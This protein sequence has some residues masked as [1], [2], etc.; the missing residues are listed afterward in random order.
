MITPTKL[1]LENKAWSEE[2]SRKD[3]EFFVQLAKEQKPDFL[4]I[5]CSDSRVPA[6]TVVNAKPGE[7]FVHRNIAN[8]VIVTDFNCLSVL[9]YAISVLKVKHVIV[10]GHYGC[11]GVRAA[12]QPQKSD[13]VITN[14]WLL[15]IKDVYR[16]HQEELESIAP[17]K[18]TDRLI[19]LNIIE[20]VYRLAH[21]SIIQSAWKHGHKPTLHGWVY[22]LNDGLINELIKLDHNTQINPIYRY[23][24]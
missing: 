13:L 19:E 10:C 14:K 5:G 23:A 22:G 24:D 2:V 6:E 18:K 8:Q 11:G 4:W 3:P 1:L 15:H 9:Q 12:L 21:T 16:L 20:Q 7:I 17:E